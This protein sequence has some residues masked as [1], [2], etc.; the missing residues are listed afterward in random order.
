M[1]KGKI[2]FLNGVSSSGKTTLA[3]ELQSQLN[4][5]Y[6]WLS[7]DTFMDMTAEKYMDNEDDEVTIMI[8]AMYRTIKTFSDMGLNTIID[9]VLCV[10]EE[11]FVECVNLLSEYPL[12]F[13]HVTCLIEELRR[14]EL[15]RGDRTIGQAEEQLSNLYP[16][17][18]IYDISVDTYNHS[19]LECYNK[20]K[21]GLELYC[22]SKDRAFKQLKSRI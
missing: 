14:R 20:I 2:I 10:S 8:S 4:E 6:Y 1:K 15:N 22:F 11:L 16:L 5:P 9:D 13:I 17:D 21:N 19:S 18:N 12:L 7:V 3:K